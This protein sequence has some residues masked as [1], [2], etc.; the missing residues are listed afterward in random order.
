MN[1]TM[2]DSKIILEAKN[3]TKTFPGVVAVNDVS[4]SVKEGIVTAIVGEN[5]AGKSTLMKILAGVYSDYIG[6]ILLKG[7]EVRFKNPREAIDAGIMLI[8][9]ELD[10]VPNLTVMENI[11]LGREPL[12]FWGLVNYRKMYVQTKDLLSKVRLKIDPKKKVGDL[13]TGQQQLVAIAKALASQ[14]MIIIMDEPTSA[15]SEKEIENLFVIVRDLRQQGKAI[16]YIS[17]KLDEVFAIA[18][19]IMIMRDGRLVARG[20]I[21][22]FS[23]DDV[24]RLMVGRSIEKFYV[25]EKSEVG[26]EVLRVEN[27]SVLDP[28]KKYLI[29]DDVSFSV[30]KGEILGVYGLIGAG[31]TELMEATFGFYHPSRVSGNVFIEGKRISVKTPIDAIRAGIGYVPEDRK[32]SG[33][34]LQLTVLVN[35]SLPSLKNLSKF[36]FIQLNQEKDL[37][38]E[39]VRRLGIKTTSLNQ[40]VEN[41]SGGNQQKV[42]L[43]KWLALRPKVLLLDEPTRGIDVNTKSELYSLISELARAGLGIVLVSSE[44]PEVLAM[45]DRIMVMSEGKKTAEFT[46]EEASEEKL[47]KAAIPRSIKLVSASS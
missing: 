23:Y 27:M 7:K 36:G 19:E 47:L 10:L 21:K 25:K 29:V 38:R 6:K 40:F 26:D 22:D 17:H 31:R 32:L 5:G 3:I 46:R 34:I 35:F 14:A 15:I 43:A 13:S 4:F 28:D 37:A 33:L 18:D 41:L 42:V 2:N 44:L 39:Y 9:Q 11:H 8:P 24:V 16:L 12:D 45:S 1:D 30:R 20:S